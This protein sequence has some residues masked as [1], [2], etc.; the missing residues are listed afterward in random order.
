[1]I[2]ALIEMLELPKFGHIT[3]SILQF[4]LFNKILLEM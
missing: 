1:M 3:K 2:T 4:K